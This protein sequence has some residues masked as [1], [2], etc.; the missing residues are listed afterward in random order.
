MPDTN[1]LAIDI[2]TQSTRAFIFNSVGEKLAEASRENLILRPEPGRVEQ[3]GKSI[4]N[5]ACAVI[6][7]VTSKVRNIGQAGLAIQRSSVIAWDRE[8]GQVLSPVLSWQDTR[9][10]AMLESL[11][12][13]RDDI[14]A[15]SGL[16]LTPYYG[17]SKLNW[18][19]KKQ[20]EI[21]EALQ[22]GRLCLGP[23][24]SYMLFKLVAQKPY[25]VDESNAARTQLWNIST[26][27]WDPQLCSYFGVPEN[28]LP[29]LLPTRA[30][31]GRVIDTNIPLTAVCGDQN[32]AFYG[33]G[34]MPPATAFINMG[35]GAFILIP[36]GDTPHPHPDLLVT[37]G[38]SD[39][40]TLQYLLEATVNGA[41]NTLSWATKKWRIKNL[42]ELLPEWLQN[43]IDPPV[44]LNTVGGLGSPWWRS[45]ID[46]VFLDA[47]PD[48]ENNPAACITAIIESIVFMLQYNLDTIRDAGETINQCRVSGGL[49]S[50]DGLCQK[51]ANLSGMPVHRLLNTETTG[52]G[53]AYLASGL[54]PPPIPVET[55]FEPV[56]DAGLKRRYARFIDGLSALIK[57]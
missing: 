32:A 11:E 42:R 22:D 49:V 28:L 43:T 16:V 31:F 53:A 44:F 3:N 21:G 26:R 51:L 54:V 47:Q 46:P 9:A 39:A 12:P 30:L 55:Y 52:M 7:A 19:L 18:L 20:P 35:T 8:T 13:H 38:Q 33:I 48:C 23:L 45:G 14:K 15:R 34:Q 40:Q 56:A 2:G 36:T 6:E 24:A 41:G 25:V 50:V 37:S 27:R 4:I 29:N 5:A 57:E 1:T 17:A 10:A